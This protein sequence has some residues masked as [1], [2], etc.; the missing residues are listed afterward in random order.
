MN[1][2]KQRQL[3]EIT[4]EIDDLK[5]QKNFLNLKINESQKKFEYFETSA[6]NKSNTVKKMK[7]ES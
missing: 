4:N 2:T 5:K 6:A 1:L 7:N 3:H